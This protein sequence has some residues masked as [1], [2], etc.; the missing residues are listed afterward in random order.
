MPPLAVLFDLD[1]T[2]IDSYAAITA[3]VNH[4]RS[5]HHLTPLSIDEVRQLVGH[6]LE[7]L[8]ADVIPDGNPVADAQSYRIH[9]PTVMLS[10]THLLPGVADCLEALRAHG[11][12]M[13]VCSN[14]PSQFST[15]LLAGL[16]IAKY[17]D[18]TLGPED[19]GIPKPHPAMILLALKRLGVSNGNALYI[20]DMEVDV[21]TAKAAKVAIWVVLT[22]S[23]KLEKI[24][25]SNP[26][27]IMRDMNEVL[28][29]IFA[30]Q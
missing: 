10:L 20:G 29:A 13:A 24:E 15:Q 7:Q 9:H 25:Q 12:K 14:K 17:F 5:V 1:G 18:A 19:A 23:D 4:V 30:A 27:R 16:G 3:S 21:K 11:I 8:M 2:L 22:G 28:H 26:D 6:G